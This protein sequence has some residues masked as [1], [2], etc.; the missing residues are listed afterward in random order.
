[1]Q[2][3]LATLALSGLVLIQAP[4]DRSTALR[5]ATVG[6]MA[7]DA[8]AWSPDGSR[9]AYARGTTLAIAD[10]RASFST[11]CRVRPPKAQ[12]SI[13]DIMWAPDGNAVAFISPRAGDRIDDG[14]DTIWLTTP[15]CSA[16][17]DLLPRGAP[18]TYAG[19]RAVDL[20]SWLNPR[21]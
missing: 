11:S 9:L 19:V 13:R 1:M 17:H 10:P 12:P 7:S 16:P 14:W 2:A 20:S 4:A 5:E 21:S 6:V 15:T 8:F 3:R 18:F